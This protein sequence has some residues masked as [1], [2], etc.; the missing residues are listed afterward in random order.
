VRIGDQGWIVLASVICVAGVFAM[1]AEARAAATPASPSAATAG[2]SGAVPLELEVVINGYPIGKIGEFVDRDDVLLAR[3][4]ELHDL[5]LRVPPSVAATPDG[6]IALGALPGVTVRFDA[7][8]QTIYITA[9]DA[10]L[11]PN[12]LRTV[13]APPSAVPLQ[14][15]VGATL[16]YDVIGAVNNGQGSASGSFDAR[17]FSPVGVASTDFLAFAGPSLNGVN[18]DRT[19]RLDST[20]VFSD[21]TH[22]R[23]YWLGDFI[24]GGLTWTRPVRLG[25]AQVTRDFSMRPDL[26]TFPVPLVSGSV[27]VPSTVDI[28]VN[29]TRVLS[30]QAQP[31]P[32]QAPQ[33]PV[34]T[35]A[36]QVQLTVTNA[37]GQ[38]VTTTLPFY[39]SSLLLAPGL[40]TYS[41]ETGWVRLNWGVISDQYGA[42]AGSGTYRLG[43]TDHLTIEGHAE[44]TK[45]QVMA[46][47]GI[48]ANA[49]D[50]AIINLGGAA[51]R[52]QGV[53]GGELSVG[54]QRL[55]HTFSF[56]ASAVLATTG[57]RDIASMNADPAPTRQ[58]TANASLSFG[59][60][61]TAG[62]AWLDVDR[63]AAA[64][65]QV[66]LTGPPAF[67]PPGGPQPP[68]DVGLGGASLPFLPA[69][70]SRILTGSYS[71]RAPHDIFIYADAFHDF[72]RKG[73][74]GASIG[75]SIPL[76]RRG[77]ASA[78]GNYQGSSPAYGQVQA[79][80]NVVNIG[81]V[82]YHA[83]ASGPSSPHEFGEVDYKS[84]W[85]LLSAGV[86]HLNGSTSFRAQAQ[87]AVSFAD[88]AFFPSNTIDQSFAVVDTGVRGVHVL[89][90]NRDVGR[91][92]SSGR[93]LAPDLRSWDVNRLSIE[94]ADVPIDAQVPYTERQVRPPDRSGIVVKFPIRKTNGA[95]LMLVDEAG[96]PIPVGSSATLEA[97]GVDYTIGYDGQAFVEGLQAQNRLVVL[98][99]EGGRCVVGFAYAPLAGDIPKL[100]PLT[101]RRDDR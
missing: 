24:T 87:G 70:T 39:A 63:P 50:F 79:Q 36:G 101:C 96:R 35:G 95:L 62:L 61:G 43:L 60:W 20:Y 52:S 28:L 80:Q 55:G 97:T 74:S 99:P 54:V 12:L 66:G 64:A 46:G 27:A 89:Y 100:G 32:F 76:G 78:S 73:G 29:G 51:S 67:N 58:I 37:L 9:S 72:A 77:S 45:G 57:F 90:E 19:V 13:S 33:L 56:G 86:D 44:G 17:V 21:F 42:F 41:V 11:L 26:V 40:H 10:A 53:T 59:K 94:P 5:G 4:Q 15:S 81:D 16:N 71:V 23:R 38:Q 84:P 98:L 75:I 47:G 34:T 91:T 22:Q 25:G 30:S 68:S 83:F 1:G 49:F 69:Q 8:S 82:G 48:V 6:L 92:D 88:G 31:G 2:P 3:R 7:A 14:A 93:L 85:S 65:S 18:Q